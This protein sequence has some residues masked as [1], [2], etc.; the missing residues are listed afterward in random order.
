M[1]LKDAA[2]AVRKNAHAPYSNFKVGAAIRAASGT[3]YVGCNV[4]NVAYPEGTAAPRGLGK[5]R[6]W[7]AGICCG[8]AM[9]FNVDDVGFLSAVID[10]A[11]ERHGADPERV[12][13]AGMSNGAMMAYR[14]ACEAPERIA[15]IVAVSGTSAVEDCA[16]SKDVAVLH[17]HGDQDENVPLAGGRGK[18]SLSGVDFRSVQET[19]EALLAQRGECEKQTSETKGSV[20]TAYTCQDGAPVELVVLK[21][22]GH[23]WPGGSKDAGGSFVASEEAWSF[24]SRFTRED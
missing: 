9:R 24:V 10:D 20:R 22:G 13:V 14:L 3:V 16:G 21:G 11:I 6:T 2:T 5:L 19:L 17:I 4:E 8:P 7:N 12:Y 18:D 15:A 23:A 1:S